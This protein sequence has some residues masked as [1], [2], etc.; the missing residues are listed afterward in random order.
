MNKD[1]IRSAVE[2]AYTEASVSVEGVIDTLESLGF[3]IVPRYPEI[4]NDNMFELEETIRAYNS[5]EEMDL[6]DVHGDAIIQSLQQRG[7][8]ICPPR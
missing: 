7:W 1:A 2:E 6:G 8:V 4:N 5:L 3:E